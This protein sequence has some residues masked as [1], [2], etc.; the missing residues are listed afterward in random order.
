ME[1]NQTPDRGKVVGA[2]ARACAVL[3]TNASEHFF[4]LPTASPQQSVKKKKFVCLFFS[5]HERE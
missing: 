3:W 2:G 4:F 1:R 5:P